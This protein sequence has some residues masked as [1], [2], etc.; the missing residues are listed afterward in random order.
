MKKKPVAK[1]KVAKTA[2]PAPKAPTL[3]DRLPKNHGEWLAKVIELTDRAINPQ[4]PDKG[5]VAQ[6]ARLQAELDAWNLA[7]K[8]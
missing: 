4:H 7:N 3:M 6:K 2:K 1:K 8:K 5:M